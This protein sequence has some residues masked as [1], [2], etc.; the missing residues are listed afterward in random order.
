LTTQLGGGFHSLVCMNT[1]ASLGRRCVSYRFA[2]IDV[3]IRDEKLIPRQVRACFGLLHRN[4]CEIGVT[5]DRGHIQPFTSSGFPWI[6]SP[7]R[8]GQ[9]FSG[10]K[11]YGAGARW[12][13]FGGAEALIYGAT[14]LGWRCKRFCTRSWIR[15]CMGVGRVVNT[16]HCQLSL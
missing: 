10:P 4:E 7:T 14:V 2:T 12:E 9:M 3:C 16:R 8:P 13:T 6:H 15:C 1:T 5:L 11:L